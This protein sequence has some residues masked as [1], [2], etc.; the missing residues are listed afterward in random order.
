LQHPERTAR[1]SR[2]AVADYQV[3]L[4]DFRPGRPLKTEMGQ[5][6]YHM[7]PCLQERRTSRCQE[8]WY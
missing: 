7:R 5:T 6:Q 1:N 8:V 4:A 3:W 2:K